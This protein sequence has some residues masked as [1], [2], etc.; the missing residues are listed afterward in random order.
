MT[1][2]NS[3]WRCP[4]ACGGGKLKDQAICDDCRRHQAIGFL[5]EW[6]LTELDDRGQLRVEWRGGEHGRLHLTKP[7]QEG[8]L[9]ALDA[10]AGLLGAVTR[11]RRAGNK[12]LMDEQ[13]AAQRDARD[14]YAEGRAEGQRSRN[15]W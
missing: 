10:I 1:A 11:A 5:V 4:G 8:H 15:D 2:T 12:A 13:R 14:A 3:G 7:L 9:Q 6:I